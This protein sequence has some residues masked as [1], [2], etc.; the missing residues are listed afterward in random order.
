MPEFP[1]SVAAPTG[2]DPNT[3]VRIVTGVRVVISRV[4]IGI[5]GGNSVPVGIRRSGAKMGLFKN[6]KSFTDRHDFVVQLS[7][8]SMEVIDNCLVN[9]MRDKRACSGR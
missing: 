9:E 6:R 8:T 2:A 4:R 3:T 5:R 7:N 1:V